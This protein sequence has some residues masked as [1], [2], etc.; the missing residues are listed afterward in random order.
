MLAEINEDGLLT[1]QAE[2]PLECYALRCWYNDV[3]R[4]YTVNTNVKVNCL[5]VNDGSGRDK[6]KS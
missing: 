6:N 1:V 3:N 4:V 2:T 5:E